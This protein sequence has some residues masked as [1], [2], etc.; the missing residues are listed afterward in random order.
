MEDSAGLSLAQMQVTTKANTAIVLHISTL[1]C[2]VGSSRQYLCFAWG[3]TWDL[4]ASI[5]LSLSQDPGW[6]W[7]KSTLRTWCRKLPA[8][9]SGSW[10]SSGSWTNGSGCLNDTL[11]LGAFFFFS[12]PLSHVTLSQIAS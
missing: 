1:C 7:R 3:I 10:N 2:K 9:Y 11:L 12:R 5:S 6:T 4:I 8:V